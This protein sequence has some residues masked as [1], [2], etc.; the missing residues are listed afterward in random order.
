MYATGSAPSLAAVIR[1]SG[2]H[3]AQSSTPK[4]RVTAEQAEPVGWLVCN[5]AARHL[6]TVDGAAMRHVARRG[7]ATAQ[8]PLRSAGSHVGF[9][10]CPVP[11]ASLPSP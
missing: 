5:P 11:N 10:A 9:K 6:V 4:S 2:P 1:R 3:A 7:Y 8:S